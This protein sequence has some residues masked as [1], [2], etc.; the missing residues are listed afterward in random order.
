MAPLPTGLAA[1][2][3]PIVA[4][5]IVV[6]ALV[7]IFAG[8]SMLKLLVFL[9]AGFVGALIGGLVVGLVA[10]PFALIG[11]VIGFVI[12]GLL[13]VFLMR[14]TVAIVL[15]YVGYSL[16][17]AIMGSTGI[18]PLAAGVVCF[19]VALVLSDKILSVAT[20]FLGGA[21]LFEGLLF[22]IPVA[23]AGL[24]A[25]LVTIA[26]AWYQTKHPKTQ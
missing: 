9:A 4:L 19:I 18:I 3:S 17:G 15:G 7:L 22:F 2:G 11:A 1:L 14:L 6:L 16:V 25:L 20:A 24:V 13:G 5:V 23:P 21:L 12:L 10:L 26:G 8:R